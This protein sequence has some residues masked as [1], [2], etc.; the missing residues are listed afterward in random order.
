VLF[1]VLLKV[2]P[3]LFLLAMNAPLVAAGT[4][5]SAVKVQS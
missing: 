4:V 3:V 5:L 2:N 1:S